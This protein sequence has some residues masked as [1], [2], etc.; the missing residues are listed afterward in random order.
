MRIYS[1]EHK[2]SLLH[3]QQAP[4]FTPRGSKS[5]WKSPSYC[6][7]QNR[8]CIDFTEIEIWRLTQRNKNVSPGMAKGSLALQPANLGPSTR[9]PPL[10]CVIP[11]CPKTY[12]F[13]W[14]PL[15]PVSSPFDPD[16]IL[17]TT[18]IRVTLPPKENTDRC[19]KFTKK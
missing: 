10:T 11:K 16:T 17:I 13:L 7:L 6:T 3:F 14:E 12:D 4:S 18:E 9:S 19:N 15:L 2:G 5:L 1:Q 8:L